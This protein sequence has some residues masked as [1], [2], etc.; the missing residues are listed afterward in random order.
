MG[1]MANH[2]GNNRS[3]AADSHRG[4]M[5]PAQQ[6]QQRHQEDPQETPLQTISKIPKILPHERVFPIQIGC[7]LFKL[8]G[9]SLS[10]DGP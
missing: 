5:H 8:S 7:E 10:S 4:H 2:H 3:S 1:A 6:Q 9:A